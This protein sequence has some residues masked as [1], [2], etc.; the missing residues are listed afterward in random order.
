MFASLCTARER[1]SGAIGSPSAAGGGG[2]GG[3]G[4]DMT[5]VFMTACPGLN[6]TFVSSEVSAAESATNVRILTLDPPLP[7]SVPHFS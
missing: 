5:V 3:E 6:Y 2:W 1:E 7:S 4:N